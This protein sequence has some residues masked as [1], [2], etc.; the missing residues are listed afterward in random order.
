MKK[1]AWIL[2]VFLFSSV[3][4]QPVA[5]FKVHAGPYERQNALVC[6]DVSVL[7]AV[8][9]SLLCLEEI[10]PQGN[11]EVP[12]QI[13]RNHFGAY[14]T[15]MLS[16]RTAA[17]AV[18]K[19]Q[20]V[21][22]KKTEA[23]HSSFEVKNTGEAFVICQQGKNILQYTYRTV[24][25]PSGIDSAYCR[26]GFIHPLWSPR[27]NVLTRIQPPDHYHHY[28]IWN[29]WTKVRYKG[30]E[31]D[32]WNLYKKEGT[33]RYQGLLSVMEGDVYAGFKV[34]HVHVVY[35]GSQAEEVALNEI[36]EVRVYNIPGNYTVVD[37]TT[38]MNPA[39]CDSFVI[40]AYR[41]QGTGF[42]ANASWTKENVTL[43]TSEGYTRRNADGTRAR[44]CIV[45]GESEQGRSGI[46]FIGHPGN[47]NFPE[48]IRIWDEKQNNGR[49][50][51]FFNFCPA[52]NISWTLLPGREYRLKY[53]WV[54]F[55]DSLSAADAE[56]AYI[57]FAFPPEVEIL[58]VKK[59]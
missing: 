39:G 29:A 30:K 12:F 27:G 38:L 24:C 7:P 20:C 51:A 44:W 5:M 40:D 9:D 52:K 26:S 22:R 45:S 43:L 50:D 25:P 48:P 58:K 2:I 4:C 47:Y 57:N 34:H 23:R 10:T 31:I 59:K 21:E 36:W 6:V 19:Y 56:S 16:G 42:R 37:F 17:G 8:D 35:P 3:Y 18:R 33:V 28:G 46:L 13:E 55:D 1:A 11:I 15:W 32:F 54:I 41:Y 53:R 49:G 14:M